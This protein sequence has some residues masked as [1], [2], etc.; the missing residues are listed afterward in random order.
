MVAA[1]WAVAA[2]A[3]KAEVVAA[4]PA[5]AGAV[6][7]RPERAKVV[8]ARAWV[9]GARAHRLGN[10]KAALHLTLQL[11]LQRLPGIVKSGG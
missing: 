9:N 6:A 3:A 8:A 11:T 2:K 7:A 10:P 4:Q 1:A 5:R